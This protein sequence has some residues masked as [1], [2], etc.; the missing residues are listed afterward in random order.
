MIWKSQGFPE[1]SSLEFSLKGTPSPTNHH[2]P[3]IFLKVKG[4]TTLAY[5]DFTLTYPHL[6]FFHLHLHLWGFCD[7]VLCFATDQSPVPVKF[8][9]VFTFDQALFFPCIEC[10]IHILFRCVWS[11]NC[12]CNL[13]RLHPISRF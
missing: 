12:F 11:H 5:C 9:E 6:L 3:S 1:F 7:H 13:Q 8:S 2:Q 10:A 4:F